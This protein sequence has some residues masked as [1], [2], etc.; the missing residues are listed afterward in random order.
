MPDKILVIE[1]EQPIRELFEAV[2][3]DQY[4]VKTAANG[5]EARTIIYQ[6]GYNPIGIVTDY[7]YPGGP[8]IDLIKEL[9]DSDKTHSLRGIVVISGGG[10]ADTANKRMSELQAHP[11]KINCVFLQK[12][13]P[14]SVLRD[15]LR[16]T[17]EAKVQ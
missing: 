9:L 6:E 8:G 11:R 7:S 12:P 2:L 1:D 5:T 13:V 15:T 4:E 14:N 3:S 16:Q 10:D 17:L